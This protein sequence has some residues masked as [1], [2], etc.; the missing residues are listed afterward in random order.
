MVYSNLNLSITASSNNYATMSAQIYFNGS[1]QTNTRQNIYTA[2][3]PPFSLLSLQ[4]MPLCINVSTI[5]STVQCQYVLISSSA[6]IY[7]VGCVI[8]AVK[9][10]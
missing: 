8:Q 7:N 5:N 9:I 2:S 4:P 6:T 10:A 3:V 1:N